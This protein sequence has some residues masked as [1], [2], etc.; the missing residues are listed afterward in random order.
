MNSSASR[1]A[2]LPL[3][4]AAALSHQTVLAEAYS[5][6][7]IGR[8]QY[9]LTDLDTNDGIAPSLTW[10]LQGTYS[11]Q[12]SVTLSDGV[13]Y[14][15]GPNT[16]ASQQDSRSYSSSITTPLSFNY[17]GYSVSSSID[18]LSASA[19]VQKGGTWTETVTFNNSFV[20]S[21]NTAVTFSA[22]ASTALSV[23]VPDGSVI[24]REPYNYLDN[25]Y[26]DWAPIQAQA[27]ATLFFS[28]PSEPSTGDLRDGL[29][30]YA[31]TDDRLAQL[32]SA[33]FS[34]TTQG[35]LSNS[36]TAQVH[37][38]GYATAPLAMVPELSSSA[39]MALGLA[40]LGA[41]MGLRR[42]RTSP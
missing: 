18:G 11:Q 36:L 5:A 1:Y 6:A 34:N 25:G 3:A 27:S 24:L 15:G 30:T 28:S 21:A 22:Q 13:G 35:S 9:T 10:G 31:T 29:R 37:I 17:Q 39:Q 7:T 40:G 4:L 19:S 26:F 42:R 32:L 41:L 12:Q 8:L 20:L 38:D 14:G 23:V 2:L 33:T 16:I